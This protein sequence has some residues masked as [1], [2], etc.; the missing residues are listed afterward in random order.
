MNMLLVKAPEKY[1]SEPDVLQKAGYYIAEY[2]KKPLIIGGNHALEVIGDTFFKS[3][4]ENSIDGSNVYIF[5]GYPSER[6]FK[7][8]SDVAAEI[9]AD[10]IIGAGGGRV[11]DTAKAAGNIA[12]LPV[13]TIPTV[14]A[15]CAAWA[16]VTIQ[17]DDEGSFVQCRENKHSPHLVLADTKILMNA[18]V[19][20]L[21]SGVVDT[22]A[23]YYE[24]RPLQEKHPENLTADITLYA[25]ELALHRMDDG[26]FKALE[27]AK[28]GIY[29]QPARDVI[30]AI[31]YIA[32]LT[33]SLQEDYGHYSFAHPFY[34]C[35][36]RLPDTRFRLHGEKVA[37]GIVTQLFLENKCEKDII[38]TIRLF[39][40]YQS[41]FTLDELGIADHKDEDITFLA[42]DI[43]T[44][45]PF[46]DWPVEAIEQALVKADA[47][48][49]RY[50]QQTEDK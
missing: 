23:K 47:L 50:R 32:G 22:F 4:E 31:I 19:R 24:T 35:S 28:M 36:T 11:L 27:D 42:R 21:F 46:V 1:M 30:D 48:T 12:G 15:T 25:S 10:V 3:L 26:V 17:Y 13:V 34:H 43:K 40:K 29:G 39:D 44:E 38:D 18:P 16:A 9:N 45:F 41:A 8:Y 49:R 33:G 37:Y 5:T 7:Y 20:Y 6:Q 2:G 14:A